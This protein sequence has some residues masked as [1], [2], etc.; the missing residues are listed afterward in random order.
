[1]WN[2]NHARWL[3]NYEYK[4]N[5]KLHLGKIFIQRVGIWQLLVQFLKWMINN[6]V[7]TI[8]IPLLN[9]TYKTLSYC[10]LNI[11]KYITKDIGKLPRWH[12][13]K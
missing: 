6:Y 3:N 2:Y 9:V 12:H 13:N 8:E 7:I 10:L 4:E 5:H 11:I 1:M